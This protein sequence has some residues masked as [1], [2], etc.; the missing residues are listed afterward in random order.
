MIP[1]QVD[2]SNYDFRPANLINIQLTDSVQLVSIRVLGRWTRFGFEDLNRLG[3]SYINPL[4]LGLSL[5]RLWRPDF[6]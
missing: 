4:S 6:P 5:S 1:V 3:L 2:S